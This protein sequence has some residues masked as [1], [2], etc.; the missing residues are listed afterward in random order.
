M[1]TSRMCA[2]LWLSDFYHG[3]YKKIIW[4]ISEIAVL[5]CG[6]KNADWIQSLKKLAKDIE[7]T[8]DRFVLPQIRNCIKEFIYISIDCINGKNSAKKCRDESKRARHYI[9]RAHLH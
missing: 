9:E 8:S 2:Q 4:E 7:E 6:H 1:T 3:N 5:F